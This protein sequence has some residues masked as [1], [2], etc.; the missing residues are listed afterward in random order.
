MSDEQGAATSGE[1]AIS[2]LA[3]IATNAVVKANVRIGPY[4]VVG[5]EGDEP[6]SIGEATV[7]EDHV[8]VEPGASIG[9]NCIIEDHCRIGRGSTIAAGSRIRSGIRGSDDTAKRHA[10]PSPAATASMNAPVSSHALVA[11]NVECAAGVQ[12]DAFAIVGWEGEERVRVGA[13][14][15]I[16]PFAL[17]EPGVTIGDDCLIDAYC[18]IA[19]GATIGNRTQ[20]LYGAAVFE[21][22]EIG[23]AC[24]IGG[25]VADRTIIE[26]C[27][28]HFGEIAHDYRTPGDLRDWDNTTA[29]SPTIRSCTV[30][31]QYAVIVGG[32]E[33]GHGCYIAAGEV[34]RVTVEPGMLYQRG[35]TMLLS[36]TRG[37][38]KARTDGN[39]T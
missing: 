12:I 29:P 22:A 9:P 13:R 21:Q 5:R 38:V 32:I 17:I 14:T 34:V 15:K 26:D 39:C 19:S 11:S 35:K 8:L 20:I 36:K 28:T 31:G 37:L 3:T 25:N 6:V 16:S 18:R 27:V 4:T 23:E 24:I 7:I 1:D 33:I 10:A 2:S 30:V